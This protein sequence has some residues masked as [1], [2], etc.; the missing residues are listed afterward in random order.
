MKLKKTDLCSQL[1]GRLFKLLRSVSWDNA[2]LRN[3]QLRQMKCGVG[4]YLLEQKHVNCVYLQSDGNGACL[5]NATLD[6][7]TD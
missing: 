7:Q 3:S 6:L 4:S 2:P 1:N 5:E